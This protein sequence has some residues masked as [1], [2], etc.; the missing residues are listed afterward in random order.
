MR[1][2]Q[3]WTSDSSGGGLQTQAERDFRLKVERDFRLKVERDFR[4][5]WRAT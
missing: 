1:L 3:R 5:K 2:K 4:L